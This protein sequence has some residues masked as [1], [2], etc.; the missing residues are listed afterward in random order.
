M[1]LVSLL[2]CWT[3]FFF[4]KSVQ[5]WVDAWEDDAVTCS[6][7]APFVRLKLKFHS[8]NVGYLV[9]YKRRKWRYILLQQQECR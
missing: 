9:C 2:V 3:W 1:T 8:N 4:T 7:E 6:Y 5:L